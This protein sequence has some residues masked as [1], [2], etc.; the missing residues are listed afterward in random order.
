VENPDARTRTRAYGARMPRARAL[1]ALA[2]V[3]ALTAPA[4]A[5]HAADT[6]K[7]DFETPAPAPPTWP[8]LGTVVD[9]GYQA[10]AFTTFLASDFGFRPYRVT[11]TGQARSG[12]VVADVG[13]DV[14]Y[15]D[16][17]DAGGCEFAVGGSSGR[18]TRTAQKITLYAGL[19]TNYSNPSANVTAQLIG[20]RADDA[21][22][23]TGAA[24]PIFAGPF[25]S[26]VT[27]TSAAADIARWELHVGGTDNVG[28]AVGFDDLTMEFPDNSLPDLSLST[29]GDV[30]AVLQGQ[31][32]DV[33][34]RITRLNGSSGPV[35]FSVGGLPAGITAQVV[36]NP[37]TGPPDT[38]TVRLTAAPDAPSFDVPKAITIT[39]DP[40]GDGA[41]APGA[42]TVSVLMRVAAD[43]ELRASGATTAPVPACTS[44][45][46]PFSLARDRAF[47]GTVALAVENL[48]AGVSAT[49]LPGA[50]IAP[51]GGFTVAGTL[52][53]TGSATPAP[54]RTLILR[55]TAPGAPDKTLA[56]GL[57]SAGGGAALGTGVGLTP[58]ALQPGTSIHVTGT[59]FCPG[60][61]VRA[62]STLAETAAVLDADG[63]GL[64]F[65]VPRLAT[66]GPVT[67]VPPAPRQ[68]YTTTNALQIKTFRG[69]YGMPFHNFDYG[70][71]SIDELTDEFGAGDLFISVNL[72]WP[73]SCSVNTGILN[74]VAAV[75]WG[76]INIALHSSHGHCFGISRGVEELM[77]RKTPYR[78]FSGTATVPY[79]LP[80]AAGPSSGL[81]DW[82]DAKHA[83][84]TSSEFLN[85][86]AHR[87]RSVAGQVARAR[88]ELT[89]GRFPIVTISHGGLLGEGHAM[90]V[91]DMAQTAT[92]TDLYVYDNNR[93]QGPDELGDAATHQAYEEASVIHVTSNQ[94]SYG[95]ASETWTGGND[96]S[97]FIAPFSTIPDDPSLPGVSDIL[98]V[99]PSAIFG[100]GG[101]VRTAD[102]TDGA[103]YLP[104]LDDAAAPGA[105][106]FLVF[107]KGTKN[108][109]HVLEGVKAGSYS[110]V[111]TGPDTAA[112]VSGVDT[113]K[114]VKDTV[115][116]DVSGDPG[117]TFRGGA[118]RALTLTLAT[119]NDK[120]G[121]SAA[122]NTHGAAG[123]SE[124]GSLTSGG[125]LRYAHDGRATTFSFT[126]TRVRRDGGGG[127]F[128]SPALRAGDGDRVTVRP[129]GG[130]LTRVR[131]TT[132]HRG[133]AT[134]TRIVRTRPAAGAG[135]LAIA[136]PTLKARRVSTR[137]TIAGLK[138]RAVLGAT[139]R[140]TRG[141]RPV[142]RRATSV[143][144]A[145]NG[146]VTVRF[147]TL[148]R[149]R[150]GTYRLAVDLRLV[151]AEGRVATTRRGRAVA[152]HVG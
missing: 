108:P 21:V 144:K 6:V 145:R 60:T 73:L 1:V 148:P 132:R 45:D 136:K 53:L 48:P 67:I 77:N 15:A 47:T 30:R 55:A 78:R 91:Y 98:S 89:A 146:A 61:R 5:A 82:L 83:G 112:G 115:S 25:D 74:P 123:G 23:A 44:V 34:V 81:S 54:A 127:T 29:A 76:V 65:T 104:A 151:T 110:E 109:T 56:I 38:A 58:R 52:R 68:P 140:V 135:R 84:Q 37:V 80:A 3:V 28:A 31:T 88:A 94:W 99:G 42:R 72:C 14:C 137:V 17:G 117:V 130:D 120:D 92:G 106:G 62:G 111:F 33:P 124:T 114:G 118:S 93:E 24:V 122:V 35:R 101:A 147:A 119:G 150:R 95:M 100:S 134:S 116:G 2:A 121:T 36:P 64:T 59:G 70:T 139:L 32:T 102:A 138:G 7:I 16:T 46:V 126:V 133:G 10:S 79:E 63:H 13:A 69:T 8:S 143:A 75:V 26:A 90:L 27:V 39:A 87:D 40:Q 20:Y 57:T 19:F 71:L 51:G 128:T 66:P 105:N 103:Q 43:F 129:V 18:L 9:D 96:G 11:A 142:A 49:L 149:L 4:G 141:G 131:V 107:P 85:A 125:T 113:A 50:T 12:S 97:L 22:A 41:V 152:V 86:W